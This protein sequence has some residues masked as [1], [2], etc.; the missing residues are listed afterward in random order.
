MSIVVEVCPVDSAAAAT[1]RAML[2]GS[3]GVQLAGPSMAD[4]VLT[5]QTSGAAQDGEPPLKLFGSLRP[6]PAAP[7]QIL[8]GGPPPRVDAADPTKTVWKLRVVGPGDHVLYLANSRAELAAHWRAAVGERI[9]ELTGLTDAAG[10][11]AILSRVEDGCKQ[12]LAN[13]PAELSASVFCV[14]QGD[15]TLVFEF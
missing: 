12:L 3:R 6:T 2:H 7:T 5:V 4:V 1:L 14:D 9:R 8:A 15:K 11:A 13:P 10:P